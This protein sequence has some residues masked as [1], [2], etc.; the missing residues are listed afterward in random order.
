MKNRI[1]LGFLMTLFTAFTFAQSGTDQMKEVMV[2]HDSI[3]EMMPDTAKLIG[4]LQ[5]QLGDSGNEAAYN[6]AISSLKEANQAMVVW[7]QNFGA[8]FTADEMYKGARLSA[9]KRGW[10]VE[11]KAKMMTVADQTLSSIEAAKA[12]LEK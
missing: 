3:M 8:R 11:E 6:E 1:L 7:M 2:L 12:L 4:K 5:S 10:L 9:E